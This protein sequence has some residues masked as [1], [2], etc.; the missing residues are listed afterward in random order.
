M[1]QVD[2]YLAKQDMTALKTSLSVKLQASIMG[3]LTDKTAS[4]LHAQALRPYSLFVTEHDNCLILRI[5]IL[6]HEAE[7]LLDAAMQV[8]EFK[9]FGLND[10]IA[11]I[12]R[13][14]HA[15][16]EVERFSAMPPIRRAQLDIVTPA[17]YKQG[18][19]YR[20]AFSLSK[21]LYTV[22]DKLRLFENI[23]IVNAAIDDLSSFVSLEEYHLNSA[24]HLVKRGNVIPGFY[25]KVN[26]VVSGRP[27]QAASISL[28]L[29]YATFSGLGAKTALGMGGLI[30][31]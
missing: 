2:I 23:N 30:L 13:K 10:P 18:R 22:A 7:P 29:R 25:G 8:K 24:K 21:V 4:Y 20:N 9:V 17:T 3:M 27:E 15:P 5:S 31:L 26:I 6:S 12:S 19:F 16:I 14:N 28:L 11:V 1:H